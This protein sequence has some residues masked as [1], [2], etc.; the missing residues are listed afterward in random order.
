[1]V[2]GKFL[3]FMALIAALISA[4]AYLVG[5]SGSVNKVKWLNIARKAFYVQLAGVSLASILLLY[6]I[7]THHFE[8]GYIYRYSSRDLGLGLLISSFWAGQE[9]SFLLW[10]WMMVIMIF[11]VHKRLGSL[12]NPTMFY[13]NLV[14]AGF[15]II[16]VKVSPFALQ[17]HVP[18]DGAGLNPLLQ[19]F[20]MIIHP[21]VLFV[22][23]AAA[24]IPLALALAALHKNDYQTWV[25]LALPWTLLT[26]ITLG[27][28]IIIGAFWAYEVL[29]WGGYWGWDPV[30]NSSLIAW[31]FII[32]LFHGLL[33]TK[34]T[35]SLQKTNLT[36]AILSY[37]MV[38]YATFL[39]RSGVLA[40]FSVHSFA[41]LGLSSYLIVFMGAVILVGAGLMF[42]RS[43]EIPSQPLPVKKLNK[44]TALVLTM[45]LLLTSAMLIWLGTSSPLLTSIF[46]QPSQV[47]IDF[48]NKMNLPLGILMALLLSWA[49]FVRWGKTE[50]KDFFRRQILTG[51]AGLVALTALLLAK[52]DN[53]LFIIFVTFSTMALVAN[54]DMFFTRLRHSSKKEGLAAPLTHIGL[55]LMFVGIILSAQYSHSER[56]VLNQNEPQQVFN[57][58]F[59]YSGDF[60]QPN[61][62]NGVIIQVEKEEESFEMRPRIYMNNYTNSMMHEP[63]IRRGIISDLYI[64]PLQIARD[65]HNHAHEEITLEK[66]EIKTWNDYEVQF[67]GFEMANHDEE[68][69]IKVLANVIF[70]KGEEIIQ[71]KPGVILRGQQGEAIPSVLEDA[72]TGK[73]TIELTALNAD[74]KTI[75]LM[76][77]GTAPLKEAP[78]AQVLIE[79]SIKRFM[80]LL[81]LGTI[82]LTA[83]TILGGYRRFKEGRR[84]NA[85]T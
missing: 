76:F 71:L 75:R 33:I 48:Y 53:W 17:E 41:D 25:K 44:E 36:L 78:T 39:T 8:I 42:W 83:G 67:T 64:S 12:E 3:I 7:L 34:K 28:G 46:G 82:L 11:I 45:F 65:E 32:A 35:G 85:Q 49:P 68:H 79:I 47:G 9:G 19:N 24:A 13:L 73:T 5:Q 62:K 43:G 38:L 22:G 26:S 30:E 66:G 57:F 27:A 74:A 18:P 20:W 37:V 23:Y 40:D 69:G 61:G 50:T 14:M 29:G 59:T 84:R 31:L 55:T 16:L 63:S 2:P 81:W 6:L 70:K 54:L 10:A 21:P 15:L 4:Y 77:H 52:M 80:A 56:I 72:E 58:T 60:Q 51:L 1:M